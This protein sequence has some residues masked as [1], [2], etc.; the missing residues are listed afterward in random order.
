MTSNR[1]RL[2]DCTLREAPLD[3]LMWGEKSIK[4]MISGLEKANVDLIEVGFLKDNEYKPGSTIF[5]RV[6]DIEPYLVN[7]KEGITYVALVDY[8]RYDLSNLSNYN[9]KS[10]DAI[11]VCFKHNEIGNVLDYAKK[12]RSK[13]YEVTIQHVD[14]LGYSDEEI[15]GFIEKVNKFK[16]LAYSIVDTFGAMYEDDMY[17][18]S[19]MAATYLD[20]DILLGFHGHNNLMLANANAQRFVKDIGEIR[21]VI[22]DSSL[23]GCGR[24]AGN[25]HTE[26]MAQ[27][28]DTKYDSRYDINELLDLIDT[29]IVATKERTSWGYS[30][31]YFIA[32]VH[33]AHTFNVKQLLKRHNLKSKDLRG[34]IN[35]LDDTQKKAYDYALLEKLYV[36]YFDKPVDDSDSIN[37][38]KRSWTGRVILLIAP[39]KSLQEKQDEI[40]AFITENNPVVI[41]VNN[42][43]EGFKLDYIFYSG[44][45]R[46]QD[47]Q[48]QN[49]KSAGSPCIILSSN[50]KTFSDANEIIVDYRSLIKFGWINIDSSAILLMR[51]LQR[52]DVNEFYVA[53]MDGYKNFGEAFYSNELDTGMDAEMRIEHTHDNYSMI[54]DMK[55]N[56]P[57]LAIHFITKS[58]YEDAVL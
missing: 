11:R 15:I 4:K 23:H 22:V 10:I 30:I 2:L 13:G 8:G 9:G 32:G 44:T 40:N 19:K 45:V 7:K 21:E 53:G 48:Y 46:Y 31:P 12:I 50:I 36:E 34:I 3:D 25:A 51:L 57:H 54:K 55:T 37:L 52:C 17:R 27:Y 28:L 20:K 6:E 33:N 14:T 41:A 5:H 49:Y 18:L 42:L 29:V 58:V 43:I 56:N 24:G 26:L 47:L 35:M 16:P 38:L 1:I 39:G